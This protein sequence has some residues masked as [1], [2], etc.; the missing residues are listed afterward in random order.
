MNRGSIAVSGKVFC[1]SAECPHQ[2]WGS[3]ASL[4]RA[5]VSLPTVQR[6]T[7]HLHPQWTHTSI[8]PPIYPNGT[9]RR[10]CAFLGAS[11]HRAHKVAI[12]PV[13]RLPDVA[14]PDERLTVMLQDGLWQTGD[15]GNTNRRE[16]A[17]FR[18]ANTGLASRLLC[19]SFLAMQASV[20][21]PQPLNALSPVVT[22]CTAS[23]T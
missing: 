5:P 9:Q 15:R 14:R 1:C 19:N 6:P 13:T 12:R 17:H 23:L 3:S 4:Q 2:L 8:P 20:R 16:F 11:A 21:A 18:Y 22:I 10:N 7:A